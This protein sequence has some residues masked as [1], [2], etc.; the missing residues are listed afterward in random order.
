MTQPC[1]QGWLSGRGEGQ[2][3]GPERCRSCAEAPRLGATQ[4]DPRDWQGTGGTL[5][6][7]PSIP[8]SR[9]RGLGHSPGTH[10]RGFARLVSLGPS[11]EKLLG[12]TTQFLYQILCNC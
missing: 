1:S 10:R 2:V 6:M 12:N 4:T 11:W 9:A 7:Q 8:N 3:L 5:C